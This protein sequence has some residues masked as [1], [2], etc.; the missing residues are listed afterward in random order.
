MSLGDMSH[1]DL[2]DFDSPPRRLHRRRRVRRETHGADAAQDDKIED[3]TTRKMIT[4]AAT[5]DI[6]SGDGDGCATMP[7]PPATS[8]SSSSSTSNSSSR[9]SSPLF[10]PPLSQA[11]LDD[12]AVMPSSKRF[13]DTLTASQKASFALLRPQERLNDEIIQTLLQHFHA[14]LTSA[15]L[16]NLPLAAFR[17]EY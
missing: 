15:M 11:P 4:D 17:A 16:G 6:D 9:T 8:C 10:A 5:M 7:T 3:A 12:Y 14:K 1:E 2:M 13:A